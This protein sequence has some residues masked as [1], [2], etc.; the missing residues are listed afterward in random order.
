VDALRSLPALDRQAIARTVAAAGR[1]RAGD[2]EPN[3][4][5]LVEP[6]APR[7]WSTWALAAA[8]AAIIVIAGATTTLWRQTHAAVQPAISTTGRSGAAATA[9]PPVIP[10]VAS[11]DLAESAPIPTQFV[12]DGPAHH[13]SVVGD[14]NGWDEHAT[15]LQPEAGSA[16][17]SATVPLQRGRHVYAFIVDSTW[18]T[19]R[20][21]PVARDPDFGVEGSVV[22]VGRP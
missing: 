22:I 15:P 6:P 5:D 3:E 21:A 8:A 11:A 17:W 1:A 16:L 7:T 9:G 20:R 10:A 13:V 4:D 18:T 12:Y 19:D 14:F 2:A